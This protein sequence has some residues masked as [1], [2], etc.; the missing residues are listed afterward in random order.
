MI[1]KPKI[2]NLHI[3]NPLA[4]PNRWSGALKV[5]M[6]LFVLEHHHDILGF[7][8][9]MQNA[10]VVQKHNSLDNI[11]DYKCALKLVQV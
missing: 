5:L 7:E 6:L 11:A 8:I 4:L 9:S 2:D 10:N 1:R 3:F